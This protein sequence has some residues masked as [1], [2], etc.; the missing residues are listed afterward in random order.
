MKNE[1]RPLTGALAGYSVT[2]AGVV[3]KD[4]ITTPA[5]RTFKART[6]KQVFLQNCKMVAA[7]RKSRGPYVCI[8]IPCKRVHFAVAELVA[9]AWLPNFDRDLHAIHFRDG[10][11]L[12][13]HANNLY[14]LTA[15]TSTLRHRL[16]RT[17][18]RLQNNQNKEWE[19]HHADGIQL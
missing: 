8:R 4:A 2:A 11:A 14:Y 16:D 3:R 17:L 12:N 1:F 7:D 9:T 18:E 15:A 19:N 10:N 5:G 6:L 13:V